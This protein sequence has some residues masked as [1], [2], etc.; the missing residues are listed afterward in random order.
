SCNNTYDVLNRAHKILKDTGWLAKVQWLGVKARKLSKEEP[1]E[2]LYYPG[3]R[4]KEEVAQAKRRVAQLLPYYEFHLEEEIERQARIE[5]MVYEIERITGDKHSRATFYR[6]AR[7]LP[8]D[9][10]WR[11]LSELKA[12]YLYGP[13]KIK[14]SLA[15]IFMDKVKRYCQEH[16]IDIGI[17]FET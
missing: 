17:K 13:L 5:N 7:S 1:W 8:E 9:V 15:A 14:T 4:A 2:I 6:I 10:I 3:A 11:L 16:G 12:D